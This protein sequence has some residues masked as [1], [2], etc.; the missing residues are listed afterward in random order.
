MFVDIRG[1]TRFA[2]RHEP[3]YVVAVLNRTLTEL[4]APLRAFAGILDKYIGD[5][6]LA[7]F[8]PMETP[9]D[10]AARSVD[11]ARLMHKAFRNLWSDS[12]DASLRELGLGIGISTGR[13][14][15][16]NVGS[17]E[18]MDYTVV[19][20]AVNVAARLQSLA[21]RGEILVSDSAYLLLREENDAERMQQTRLRGRERPLDVYRL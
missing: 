21:K 5:G 9:A 2:E 6:F 3:Q 4:T 13:V 7:F 20:D 18:S 12:P 17:E 14:V 10:A 19:G 15:V 8:E 11:A 16:G 1:F